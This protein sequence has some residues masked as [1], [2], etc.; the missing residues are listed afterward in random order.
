MSELLLYHAILAFD[1][2]ENVW[3]EVKNEF[4]CSGDISKW[5]Y[6][7][8]L[9]L[10]TSSN[11]NEGLNQVTKGCQLPLIFARWSLESLVHIQVKLYQCVYHCFKKLDVLIRLRLTLQK[12]S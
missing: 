8:S 1:P 5:N 9:S 11:K 3:D 4:L 6:D 7:I 2:A 12:L 10:L